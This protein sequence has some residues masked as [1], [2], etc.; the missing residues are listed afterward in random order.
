MVYL[1]E[2]EVQQHKR[3]ADTVRVYTQDSDALDVEGL[4]PGLTL[5]LG[6]IFALPELE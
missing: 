6:E 4:F 3:G 2:R 1:S 5:T